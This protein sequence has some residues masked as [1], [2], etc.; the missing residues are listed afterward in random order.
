MLANQV[1]KQVLGRIDYR[2]LH[3][4]IR[5]EFLK[6]LKVLIVQVHG[7]EAKIEGTLYGLD[8]IR[9]LLQF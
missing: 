6:R 8:Y 2:A 5:L 3:P 9:T 7:L 1:L 4:T